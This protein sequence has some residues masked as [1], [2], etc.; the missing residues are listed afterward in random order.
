MLRKAF[1]P[2][3]QFDSLTKTLKSLI[4]ILVPFVILEFILLRILNRMGAV[5]PKSEF[6][7]TMIQWLVFIGEIALNM[8]FLLSIFALILIALILAKKGNFIAGVSS[9]IFSVILIGLLFYVIPN[10]I[11]ILVYNILSLSLFVLVTILL[12]R[13]NYDK[14]IFLLSIT[15]AYFCSYY[16]IIAS[17]VTSLSIGLSLPLAS[18]IFSVGELLTLVG[19]IFAFV[20][21]KPKRNMFAAITASALTMGFIVASRGVWLS[22]LST[23]SL[24]FTLH[25][26]ILVYAIALWLYVY[27]VVDLFKRAKQRQMAYGLLLIALGG[28][29]LQITYFNQLA[30]LGFL[31][32]SLPLLLKFTE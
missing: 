18:E 12:R 23:W 30:L 26:P 15:F 22:L 5:L 29:M 21:F 6:V 24:Y 1:F 3:F 20:V 14:F 17:S 25:L 8:A 10:G 9:V 32:L 13:E 31:L 19:A 11:I 7:K 28:R 4:K 16:F 27:V 2:N